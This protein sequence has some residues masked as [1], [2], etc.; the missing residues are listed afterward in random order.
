MV[1]NLNIVDLTIVL[2]PA[3]SKAQVPGFDRVTGSAGSVLFLKKN[4]NDVV[5]EKKSQWVCNRVLIGSCRVN[6]VAR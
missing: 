6:R 4:Q 5:L 3:R 2:R 1:F